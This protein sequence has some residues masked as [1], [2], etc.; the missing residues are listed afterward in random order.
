MGKAKKP[1]TQNLFPYPFNQNIAMIPFPPDFE[2]LKF[3][4]Y[5]GQGSLV[6]HI[7]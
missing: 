3:N 7:K 1:H 5:K 4:K 6:D 2:T